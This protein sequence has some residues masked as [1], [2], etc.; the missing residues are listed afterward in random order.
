MVANNRCPGSSMKHHKHTGRD[1]FPERWKQSCFQQT[2]AL[3]HPQRCPRATVISV[4]TV[5]EIYLGHTDAVQALFLITAQHILFFCC[6][7]H[8]FSS[9]SQIDRPSGP[10][11]SF[12]QTS[13]SPSALDRVGKSHLPSICGEP[14][15]CYS[16]L[17]VSL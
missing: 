6:W 8:H 14:T 2:V 10:P 12:S 5:K 1:I 3:G 4:I 17:A 15:L 16:P 7:P 11:P 9:S 13:G